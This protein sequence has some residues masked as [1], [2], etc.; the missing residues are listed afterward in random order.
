MPETAETAVRR[1][2]ERSRSMSIVER[3]WVREFLC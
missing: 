1:V 3:E 2:L